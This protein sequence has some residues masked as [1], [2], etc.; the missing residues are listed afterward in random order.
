MNK[1]NM[2]NTNEKKKII[3]ACYR[4][5][6]VEKS[7]EAIANLLTIEKIKK[8]YVLTITEEKGPGVNVD[9]YLGRKD[10]KKF[11]SNLEEDKNI[12]SKRY[13]DEI[14]GLCKNLHIKCEKIQRKGKTSKIILDEAK[15]IK[16]SHIVIHKSEKTRIDK[17]LTGS[18]SDEVCQESMCIVSIYE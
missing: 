11:E 13:T 5:P 6:Y 15:R 8:V 3:I 16:P 9:S 7:L 4:R 18:V 17:K 1:K 2:E 14:I 12:R 10:V